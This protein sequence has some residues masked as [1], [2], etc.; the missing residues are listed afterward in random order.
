MGVFVWTGFD[1]VKYILES[2][3]VGVE[4][5]FISIYLFI[6]NQQPVP[7]FQFYCIFQRT[8]TGLEMEAQFMNPELK[9]DSMLVASRNGHSVCNG[10]RVLIASTQPPCW[11]RQHAPGCLLHSFCQVVWQHCNFMCNYSQHLARFFTTKPFNDSFGASC[12][13]GAMWQE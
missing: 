7:L 9:G 6:L 1:P 8:G 2:N 5:F 3:E 11:Q 13:N 4:A 10:S 12:W